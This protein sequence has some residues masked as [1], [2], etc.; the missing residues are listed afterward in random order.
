MYGLFRTHLKIRLRLITLSVK[1]PDV[2]AAAACN[3]YDVFHF[4][5]RLF[6]YIQYYIV[7]DKSLDATITENVLRTTLHSTSG[8]SRIIIYFAIFFFYRIPVRTHIIIPSD[9]SIYPG[10]LGPCIRIIIYAHNVIIAR[11]RYVLL[12]HV[13][14]R[15]RVFFLHTLILTHTRS[16]SRTHTVVVTGSEHV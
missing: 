7:H 6:S 5:Q 12:S 4:S 11:G 1:T 8:F 13:R 2:N 15:T 16:H 14:D 3:P 10:P 9:I